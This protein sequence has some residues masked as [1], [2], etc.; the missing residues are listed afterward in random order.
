VSRY[1][2]GCVPFLNARPLIAYYEVGQGR[3][4]AEVLFGPPSEL[5]SWVEEGRVDVALASSFFLAEK[6][7]MR[8]AQGISISSNGPVDS[9]RLFSKVP[10][11]DICSVALDSS[12]RTSIHLAQIILKQRFGCKPVCEVTAPHLETMLAGHDAA[13]L[14]GDAGME[15]SATGLHVLDLGAAWDELVGL[16]FVWALWLGLDGLTPGLAESLLRAKAYGMRNLEAIAR[17]ESERLG[18]PYSRCMR[19]VTEVIDYELTVAH[20]SGFLRFTHDCFE[21]GFVAGAPTTTVV[22]ATVR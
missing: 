13:L 12:S 2:I 11:A 10:F 18:W 17:G 4:E 9:V 8:A 22:E 19:Y 5:A 3:D 21:A 14:I 16:P 15:A 1:R 7:E 20:W 6:T